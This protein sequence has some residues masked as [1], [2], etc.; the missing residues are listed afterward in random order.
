MK[1]IQLISMSN[2]L[3]SDLQIVQVLSENYKSYFGYF[4]IYGQCLH[5]RISHTV[6]YRKIS[7]NCSPSLVT[8]C[9]L[10][11]FMS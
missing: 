3:L 11:N 1:V 7:F 9:W 5:N 6:L 8:F 2:L 10:I 4:R